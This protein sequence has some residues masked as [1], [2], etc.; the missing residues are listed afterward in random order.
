MMAR[1]VRMVWFVL[2][3]IYFVYLFIHIKCMKWMQQTPCSGP[4][5]ESKIKSARYSLFPFVMYI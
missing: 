2:T 5:H 1:W 3:N 4:F